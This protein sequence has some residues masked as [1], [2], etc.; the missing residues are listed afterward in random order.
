MLISKLTTPGIRRL[1]TSGSSMPVLST[2]VSAMRRSSDHPLHRHAACSPSRLTNRWSTQADSHSQ[3]DG[4]STVSGSIA[5]PVAAGRDEFKTSAPSHGLIVE[6]L[7]P[8]GSMTQGQTSIRRLGSRCPI[9]GVFTIDANAAVPARIAGQSF[10][11]VG[12]VPQAICA[13]STRRT[14]RCLEPRRQQRKPVSGPGEFAESSCVAIPLKSRITGAQSAGRRR[15]SPSE[16]ETTYSTVCARLDRR[17]GKRQELA[18]PTGLAVSSDGTTLY[19]AAL[20]SSKVGISPTGAL[21]DDTFVPSTADQVPLTGGGRPA[22][23]LTKMSAVFVLTASTMRSHRRHHDPDGNGSRRDPQLPDRCR[24]WRAS[25]F[26]TMLPTPATTAT[27]R[28]RTAT[29]SA[30]WMRSRGI[31]AT[32]TP[33]SS[34]SGSV[35]GPAHSD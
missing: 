32:P 15:A 2:P 13:R 7:A 4:D 34:R 3:P 22:S 16:Q 17:P 35:H 10:A 26:S 27:R 9:A 23:C 21:E 31:S 12:T 11:H 6:V 29:C 25:A 30:T 20:G 5:L 14:G 1:P 28:A 24:S 8:I 19:V 18:L 33:Q